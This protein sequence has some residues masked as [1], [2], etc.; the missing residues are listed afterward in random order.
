[1][2]RRRE[3]AALTGAHEQRANRGTFNLAQ[4]RNRR[5]PPDRAESLK[6]CWDV[7]RHSQYQPFVQLDGPALLSTWRYQPRAA[8]Q[9]PFWPIQPEPGRFRI[10]DDRK[11]LAGPEI[12]TDEQFQRRARA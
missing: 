8:M 4:T 2:D 9:R 5:P 10:V 6:G 12:S 7:T 1:M 3:A 11:P